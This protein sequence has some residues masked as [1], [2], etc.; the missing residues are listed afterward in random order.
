[1]EYTLIYKGQSY[2]LPKFTKSVKKEIDGIN[3]DNESNLPDD[4]KFLNMYLFVKKSV[5][6]D[7]SMQIFETDKIDDM[8]LNDINIAYCSIC[9]AYDKPLDDFKQESS[10]L[11]DED[12]ELAI[13]FVKNAGNIQ[14]M[15]QMFKNQKAK[16]APFKTL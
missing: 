2:D 15:E 10:R 5:G 9:E 1:M 4:K 7:A 16:T 13:E 3:R 8:D 12:R 11:S 6:D 14:K